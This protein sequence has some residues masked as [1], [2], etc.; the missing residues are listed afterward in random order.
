MITAGFFPDPLQREYEPDR[1]TTHAHRH[2]HA[3]PALPAPA[4][5]PDSPQAVVPAFASIP[6]DDAAPIISPGDRSRGRGSWV[7]YFTRRNR[8]DQT[9]SRAQSTTTPYHHP[10]TPP[11][12]LTPTHL[13]PGLLINTTPI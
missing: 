11:P 8:R 9:Q 4:R 7:R 2:A 1:S 12:P 6:A 5:P 3:A 13:P 10:F